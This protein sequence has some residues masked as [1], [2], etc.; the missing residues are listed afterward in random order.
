MGL[1][2]LYNR[3]FELISKFASKDIKRQYVESVLKAFF[4]SIMGV[5]L[6][7]LIALLLLKLSNNFRNFFNLIDRG[8]FFIYSAAL[9]S[10]STYIFSENK[11]HIKS[12]IDKLLNNILIY[13]LIFASVMYGGIFLL[14]NI[15]YD[16]DKLPLYFIRFLSLILFLTSLFSLFKALMIQSKNSL[17]ID[18]E[19]ESRKDIENIVDEIENNE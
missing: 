7:F 16:L 2:K 19:E 18:V 12:F 8:D 14:H 10:S 17:N 13:F 9:F 6:P 11:P 1:K 3:V 5:I 15:D 4:H